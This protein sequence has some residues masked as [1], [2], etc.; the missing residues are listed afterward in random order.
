MVSKKTISE[1]RRMLAW[2]QRELAKRANLDYNT[3]R[4]AESGEVVASRSA[5]AIAEAF[6]EALGVR[7]LATDI[8]GLNVS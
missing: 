6:S 2:S 4:K 3:V 1:Y 5:L 7:V 8:E